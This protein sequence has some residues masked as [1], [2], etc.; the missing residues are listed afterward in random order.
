[1]SWFPVERN[2]ARSAI[3]TGERE[4]RRWLERLWA[5]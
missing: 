2:I 3:V 5:S 1:M 4:S